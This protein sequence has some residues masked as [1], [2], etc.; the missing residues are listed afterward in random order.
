MP[1]I[2]DQE[3]LSNLETSNITC[4]YFVDILPPR[5]EIIIGLA[6]TGAHMDDKDDKTMDTLNETGDFNIRVFFDEKDEEDQ[7]RAILDTYGLLDLTEFYEDPYE[8]E[9]VLIAGNSGRKRGFAEIENFAYNI[10]AKLGKFDRDELKRI[11][12]E[13]KV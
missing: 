7:V 4:R 13:Q 1:I 6:T 11:Y 12:K 3:A 5:G 8:S 10:S 2:A 9:P